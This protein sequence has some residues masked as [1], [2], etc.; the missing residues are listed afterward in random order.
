MAT[1]AKAGSIGF[2]NWVSWR[3]IMVMEMASFTTSPALRAS[4]QYTSAGNWNLENILVK[5]CSMIS[6]QGPVGTL[7]QTCNGYQK[8]TS[9]D[10]EDCSQQIT[11]INGCVTT[12]LGEV[13]DSELVGYALE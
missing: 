3:G 8:L 1:I 6:L 2:P 12:I 13:R 10:T 5:T 9:F 4:L 11:F 7:R